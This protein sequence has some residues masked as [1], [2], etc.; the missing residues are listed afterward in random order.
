MDCGTPAC[1]RGLWTTGI[2]ADTKG[3]VE[4]GDCIV[5]D[6]LE[7]PTREPTNAEAVLRSTLFA[8]SF[9]SK[10]LRLHTALRPAHAMLARARFSTARTLRSDADASPL[11][12]SKQK[13]KTGILPPYGP[14]GV[15]AALEAPRDQRACPFL[16]TRAP[17]S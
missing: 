10:S 9:A 16:P 4:A 6:T 3:R 8:M 2:P 14:V 5:F 17:A 15:A 13:S 1:Y 7:G 11:Q 12:P